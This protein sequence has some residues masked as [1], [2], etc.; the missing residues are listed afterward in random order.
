MRKWMEVVLL[1]ATS[2][3]L[4]A[5]LVFGFYLIAEMAGRANV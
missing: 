3:M 2:M 5:S 1:F 4:G